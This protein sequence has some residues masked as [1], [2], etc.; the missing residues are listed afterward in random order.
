[1]VG[2]LLEQGLIVKFLLRL[3]KSAT[4]TLSKLRLVYRDE[5][6]S[7][8]QILEWYQRFKQGREDDKDDPSLRSPSTAKTEESFEEIGNV[9]LND[10]RLSIRAVTEIVGVDK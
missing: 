3:S 1:M 5:C 9:I 7:R 8:T 10:H 4:Q 2:V 6:L